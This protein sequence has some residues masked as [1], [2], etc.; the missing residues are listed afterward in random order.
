MAFGGEVAGN[1]PTIERS[2]PTEVCSDES[3][4]YSVEGRICFTGLRALGL[5]GE[6]WR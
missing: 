2:L 4:T 3:E 5:D 6:V 1:I